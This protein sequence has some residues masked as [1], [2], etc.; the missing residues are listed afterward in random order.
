[1][2]SCSEAKFRDSKGGNLETIQHYIFLLVEN[3]EK[4]TNFFASGISAHKGQIIS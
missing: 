4:E 2:K 1:M 3:I